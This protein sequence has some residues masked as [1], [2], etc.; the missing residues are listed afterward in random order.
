M[1]FRIKNL[2][3]QAK[4]AMKNIKLAAKNKD[5][6]IESTNEFIAQ[7][8]INCQKSEQMLDSNS[9]TDEIGGSLRDRWANPMRQTQMKL[10]KS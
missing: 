6:G 7:R 1:D 10:R 8:K 4:K 5:D 2:K 3:A 9:E